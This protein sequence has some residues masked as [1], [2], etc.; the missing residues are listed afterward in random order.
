[1][2]NQHIENEAV[3]FLN[4][5]DQKQNTNL[6]L[7]VLYR[8]SKLLLTFESLEKSFPEILA[9]GAQGFPLLTAILIEQWEQAPR[10]TL[11]HS[12][13]ATQE[14][15][16]HSTINAREAYSYLAGSILPTDTALISR[17][18]GS[19]ETPPL[20]TEYF[21]NYIVLPL[22]ISKGAPPGVLQFQGSVPLTEYD[23]D[24]VNALADLL[25]VAL[26]SYYK[27]KK[28]ALESAKEVNFEKQKVSDL[29]AERELRDIFISTLSH[30]LRSPLTAAMISAQLI[31]RKS[32]DPDLFFTLAGRIVSSISR[33]DEMIGDL[34]DVNRIRSG[35]KLP[36]TIETFEMSDLIKDTLLELSTIHGA[37]FDLRKAERVIG[38][39]DRKAVRR[40]IENLCNN[41]IKY[42]YP[43]T[44]VTITLEQKV[45][46]VQISVMNK[47]E[48]ISAEDQQNL[49][50]PFRRGKK[51]EGSKKGWG[52][53]L[54]LVRGVAE[55]HG[56]S[57]RVESA[58][59]KGTTFIV[60]LPI[61]GRSNT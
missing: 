3:S 5:L 39:W 41:A 25:T 50:L 53:G 55:A 23:L 12:E 58:L 24:F 37:R 4:P 11:W 19:S 35:S 47:G 33:A 57:A 28:L 7:R 15:I 34:L 52:I 36:L 2:N 60:T 18:R 21:G 61:D 27:S 1:M 46:E 22:T 17:I 26:D 10:I 51:A 59:E 40:I 54:T 29:E 16:A 43:D 45:N 38:N 6:R 48:L 8:I 49:F 44:P 13:N 9:I 42:G 56:G 30:D 32:N 14:Q 20:T 31:L